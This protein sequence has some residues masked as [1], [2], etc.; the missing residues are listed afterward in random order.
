MAKLWKKDKKSTL[1]D[2]VRKCFNNSGSGKYTSQ[3]SNFKKLQNFTSLVSSPPPVLSL[4][5]V[6]TRTNSHSAVP[7]LI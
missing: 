1:G 3:K 7:G 5:S 2:I 4:Q 6:G